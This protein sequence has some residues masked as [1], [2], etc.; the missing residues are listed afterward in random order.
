MRGEGVR[1]KGDRRRGRWGRREE[2]GVAVAAA[3]AEKKRLFKKGMG[4]K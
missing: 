4:G 3:A 2:E 1:K